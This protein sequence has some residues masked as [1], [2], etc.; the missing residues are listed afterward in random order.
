MHPIHKSN[1][2]DDPNNF[3]GISIAS[4]FG[5]LFIKLL[6][7]RLQSFVDE[8]I[9]ISKHQGSGKINSHTSDHLM[10]IKCLIDKIVK[11]Q[12]NKLYAC[13]VDVKKAYDCTSREI[14]FHKLLT[15]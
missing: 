2:K 14:L 12:K 1:E 6:K 11:G 4:C 3:R 10:V 7:N 13:F 15:E 8:N 5:K 9:P